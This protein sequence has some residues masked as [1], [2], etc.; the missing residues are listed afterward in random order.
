M[1]EKI[2]QA[3]AQCPICGKTFE[4]GYYHPANQK[5]YCHMRNGGK[6]H[7]RRAREMNWNMH[8]WAS[9]YT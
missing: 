4:R 5:L 8:N 9:I 3:I 2:N 7:R 1:P 6:A